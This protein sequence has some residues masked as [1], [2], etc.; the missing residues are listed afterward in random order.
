MRFTQYDYSAASEF[1]NNKDGEVV[2]HFDSGKKL[3][4]SIDRQKEGITMSGMTHLARR[5]AAASS[6]LLQTNSKSAL[7]QPKRNFWLF[8]GKDFLNCVQCPLPT[9]T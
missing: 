5:G 8:G 6:K 3:F 4:R 2:K 1:D 9:Q 7:T